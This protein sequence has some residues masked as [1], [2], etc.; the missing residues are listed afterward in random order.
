M[1]LHYMDTGSF[2]LNID[3]NDILKELHTLNNLIVFRNSNENYE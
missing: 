3:T 2:I 1:R